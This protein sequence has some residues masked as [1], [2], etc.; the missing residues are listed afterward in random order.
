MP[1]T[2]RKNRGWLE[3]P[4]LFLAIELNDGVL[5]SSSLAIDLLKK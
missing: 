3:K 2:K 5:L 4:G 1:K